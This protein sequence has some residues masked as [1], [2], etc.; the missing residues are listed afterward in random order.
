MKVAFPHMGSFYIPFGGFLR[1]L[2]VETVIPPKPSRKSIALGARHAPEFICFPFKANLGDLIMALERGADTLISVVGSWSCRFGY[3]GR[4][5][6]RILKDLGYTF[7]SILFNDPH[8]LENYRRIKEM[9]GSSTKTLHCISK[10]LMVLWLKLGLVDLA[11]TLSRLVRPRERVMGETERV[12]QK[13][14]AAVDRAD[15]V[16]RLRAMRAEIKDAFLRIPTDDVRSPLKIQVVGETYMVLEPRV[17]FDLLRRLGEMGCWADPFLTVR[18]WVLHPFRL[19]MGGRRG[20]KEAR[21]MAAQFL[22][23]PLGGEEQPSVG[24][25]S[26]DGYDGVI[27][28][29][30]F[31]CMPEAVAYPVLTRL[32]KERHIP[33]LSLSIDEHSSEGGFMTRIEAF[34]D[35]VGQRRR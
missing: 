23:Y 24:Y 28:L 16:E 21:R 33:V 34:L 18:K 31:T 10:G 12:L 19:G 1:A 25:T 9:Q 17:N 22:P 7:D 15:G 26:R 27:H 30:P 5:H 14:L 13:V 3:Y 32:S 2:G 11:E 8:L 29:H 4:L 20:E 35:L 6:H